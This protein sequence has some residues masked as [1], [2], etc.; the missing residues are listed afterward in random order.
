M[1]GR[2]FAQ[3]RESAGKGFYRGQASAEFQQDFYGGL[4]PGT[5]AEG[6][7]LHITELGS[8]ADVIEGLLGGLR[9][10]MTYGGAANIAELQRKAE[11][12]RVTPSYF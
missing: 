2:L 9:S 6:R 1:V 7:A 10:G 8:A 11:F 3:T 4:K 5:V 12:E